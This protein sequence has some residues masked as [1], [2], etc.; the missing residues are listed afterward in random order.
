MAIKNL[1]IKKKVAAMALAWTLT[2]TALFSGCGNRQVVDIKRSFNK[3][4]IF[5]YENKTATIID[6]KSWIEFE[7]KQIK[8]QTND[9]FWMITSYYDTKLI[10][11]DDSDVTAEELV[12]CILGEGAQINYFSSKAKVKTK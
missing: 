6:V 1:N 12:Q 10:D 7:G 5:D 11:D 8:I 4:I 2:T 9:D 3:A